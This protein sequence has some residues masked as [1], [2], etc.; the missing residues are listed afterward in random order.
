MLGYVRF[1]LAMLV[2][3]AHLT[4]GM[5]V[6]AHW[7]VFAV[8]GFYLISGYLMTV[9]LNET[10][11]FRFSSFAI[12]RFLRLFPIYYFVLLGTLTVVYFNENAQLFHPA[13]LMQWR[14]ADFLG[15]GLIFPFEF[16]D[17]KFRLV[18]PAW[19]VAV[20]LINY[21]FLWLLIA[22]SRRISLA[23]VVCS[24]VYHC[25]SVVMG[26]SWEKRYLPFYAAIL[27][28]SFGSLLYFIRESV[29]VPLPTLAM[30]H[31]LK[32]SLAVWIFNLIGCGLVS[33][34]GKPSFEFFFYGNIVSLF[35]LVGGLVISQKEFALTKTEKILGDMAYPIFLTHWIV[36]FGISSLINQRRG[37]LLFVLS[38]LPL[39]ALSFIL[40]ELANRCFEP[41]RSK[42][43]SHAKMRY[44]GR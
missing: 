14:M 37:I 13:W 17:S 12:N 34:L 38:L 24:L 6:F 29:S 15:N 20:E 25:A 22:R 11:A 23:A 31:F 19:S 33:G 5:R 27:P 10:Y 40:S 1:V 35:L 39:L 3:I 4:G 41:L 30:R 8:F 18:P 32:C 44:A 9:I 21:F 2:V 36:G 16:Y 42:I 43:R 26:L 7:G 28:F